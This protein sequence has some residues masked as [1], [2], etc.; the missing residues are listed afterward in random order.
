MTRRRDLEGSRTPCLPSPETEE[1]VA[2]K[3]LLHCELIAR[4]M[5]ASPVLRKISAAI[6]TAQSH[7]DVEVKVTCETVNDFVEAMTLLGGKAASDMGGRWGITNKV[8]E[9]PER[10]RRL[11]TSSS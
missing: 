1:I 4:T 2:E 3:T 6:T 8:L 11:P 9:L 5:S 7:G 10:Q